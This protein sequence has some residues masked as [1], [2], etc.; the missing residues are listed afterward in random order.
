MREQGRL[1]DA[2]EHYER[3]LVIDPRSVEAKANLSRVL[4]K[5]GEPARAVDLAVEAIL[6]GELPD[7]GRRIPGWFADHGDVLK[8]IVE[9]DEHPPQRRAGAFV[10]L[11]ATKGAEGV[12]SA[13]TLLESDEFKP[14]REIIE[15]ILTAWGAEMKVATDANGADADSED[16]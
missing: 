2:R 16:G 1:D 10:F 7:R 3:A 11:A 14:V 5:T 12:T 15:R 9:S 13:S 8:T 4:I 6:S